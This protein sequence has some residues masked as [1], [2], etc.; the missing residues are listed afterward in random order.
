M[1]ITLRITGTNHLKQQLD[2]LN[3]K[4][5]KRFWIHRALGRKIRTYSRQRI[6][7]QTDLQGQRYEQRVSG[8]RKKMETGLGK[9]MQ[10]YAG[11]NNAR[12]TW[13]NHR[14]AKI[15]YAQQ[16]GIDEKFTAEKAAKINGKPDYNAPATRKQAKALRTEGYTVSRGK[17]K[18]RKIPSIK[19]M[20]ENLKNGQAG[21]VLSLMRNQAAKKRWT[22]Q[23]P[24]RSFLGVDAKQERE[25]LSMAAEQI[26]KL[27]T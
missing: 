10:V 9:K 7:Q 27:K 12:V 2:V 19:W 6:R 3:L 18:K 23:L 1:P 8:K 22:V 4:G 24:A 11:A 15:A 21:L 20:T 16:R 17:G 26:L 5:K 13:R 14:T 25:L